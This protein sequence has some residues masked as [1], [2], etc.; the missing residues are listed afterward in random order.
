MA[1]YDIPRHG[2]TFGPDEDEIGGESVIDPITVNFPP[3][4]DL[5]RVFSIMN[6]IEASMP[7][8]PVEYYVTR[9]LR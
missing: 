3:S 9:D 7:K 8:H 1:E 5:R 2:V 4:V 6:E